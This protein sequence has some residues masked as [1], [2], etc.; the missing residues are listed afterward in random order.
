MVV[1]VLHDAGV[2]A[3]DL[4]LHRVAVAVDAA[5]ADAGGTRDGGAQAGDRQAA[6]PAQDALLAQQLERRG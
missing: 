5:V 2:E 3:R 1:F 4:P 6:F